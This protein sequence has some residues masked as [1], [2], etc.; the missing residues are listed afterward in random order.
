ME[1]GGEEEVCL[2]RFFLLRKMPCKRLTGIAPVAKYA[3][4]VSALNTA[5]VSKRERTSPV[6]YRKRLRKRVA[7]RSKNAVAIIVGKYC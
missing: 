3:K 6:K 7:E 2:R 1:K 5:E 4:K